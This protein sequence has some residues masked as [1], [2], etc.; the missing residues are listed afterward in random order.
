[1]TVAEF[2]K[3]ELSVL[4][5]IRQPQAYLALHPAAAL[6]AE[7]GV[8]I[9]L[10]PISASP[11]KAPS[12]PRSGDDRGVRHHRYRADA[13]AREIETY[14]EVQGLVI[15]GYYRDVDPSLLNL[16]WLWL[17]E[18][19]PDRLFGFLVEAFRAY[20]A[21]ELDVSSDQGVDSLL[22]GSDV[23][24]ADFHA[25]RAETGPSRAA[26]LAAELRERSLS[27]APC[28]VVGD[29][30]FVGRQHLPMIRWLLQGRSGRGPI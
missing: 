13:I 3:S 23:E 27:R 9:N 20:W 15:K 10:L 6:A 19:H 30:V 12:E 22:A 16:A 25:W 26:S 7:C 8:E 11:L 28:Y 18:Q 2:E 1:M 29:E 21:V 14:A 17:R 5:D 4:L 24:T